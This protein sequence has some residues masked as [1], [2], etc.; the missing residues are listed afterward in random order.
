MSDAQ[1]SDTRRSYDE[2]APGYAERVA[3]LL[4]ERPYLRACV[5]LVPES[6][7]RAGG[8]PV[9][10]V[11]CGPGSVTRHLHDL[12]VDA[13]GI[14]LSPARSPSTPIVAIRRRSKAG[15]ATPGSPSRPPW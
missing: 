8:D 2:E 9:A 6:V 5:A 12:G 10:D 11:G 1:V 13:F 14:D 7:E 4:A 15:C 3:G